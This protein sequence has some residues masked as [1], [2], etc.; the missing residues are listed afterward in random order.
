MPAYY[1][2]ATYHKPRVNAAI[3]ALEGFYLATLNVASFSMFASGAVLW[4]F[5]INSMEDLRSMTRGAGS[6]VS[7]KGKSDDELEEEIQ[8]WLARTFVGRYK[9]EVDRVVE[10]RVKEREEAEGKS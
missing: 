8:E 6:A 7:A 10:R 4:K 5:G 3:D 9:D 2:S 1:T